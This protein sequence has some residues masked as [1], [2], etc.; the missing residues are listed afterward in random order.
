M[1]MKGSTPEPRPW[2]HLLALTLWLCLAP[3]IG[4]WKLWQ[5]KTL[6]VSAKWRV[7]VYL[8]VLPALVY[9][10]VS[11]SMTNHALLRMIP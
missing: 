8:F 9:I 2:K 4:L 10:T 5:D 6:S 3:P 1:I 7:L 11:I